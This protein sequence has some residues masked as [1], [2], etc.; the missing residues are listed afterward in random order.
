MKQDD[1]KK[2]S[3][4]VDEINEALK[5]TYLAMSAQFHLLTLQSKLPYKLKSIQDILRKYK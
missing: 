5:D 2:I 3:A 1:I 4:L